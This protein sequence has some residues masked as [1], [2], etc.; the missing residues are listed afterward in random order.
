MESYLKTYHWVSL[1]RDMKDAEKEMG[2]SAYQVE[3]IAKDILDFASHTRI[4][5]YNLFTQ[6]RG[7]DF[8]AMIAKLEAKGYSIEMVQRMIDNEEFWKTTL[9]LAEE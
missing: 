9:E 8:E 6:K 1:L 4:R 3:R 7:Q 2:N 5:Q